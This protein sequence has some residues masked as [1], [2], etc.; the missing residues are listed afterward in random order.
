M[1]T[2]TPP[3]AALQWR[4]PRAISSFAVKALCE[5]VNGLHPLVAEILLNRGYS[6][7]DQLH[8]FFTPGLERVA[9]AADMLHL[10]RAALRVIHAMEEGQPILVYGDYDVDGTCS[11][12]MM[13]HFL[14]GLGAKCG[15]YNPD[16]YNEGYGVS[17]AGIDYAAANGYK[18]LLTLD[19]GIAAVERITE[20]QA[21]G[22]DVVVCDH[23]L[24]GDVMPPAYAILNPKQEG[25]PLN[26]EELCGCGVAFMLIRK[27][28]GLMDLPDAQWLHYLPYVAVATCCDIVDLKGINRSL[29]KAGLESMNANAPVGFAALLQVAGYQ[30]KLDVSDV[31]FKIGPRINAAGRLGHAR[32]AVQL[33]VQEQLSTALPLATG[34]EMRNRERRQLDKDTTAVAIDLMR[35]QDADLSMHS[36]LVKHPDWHKGVIGI[37]ASRLTEVCYRPTIVFAEGKGGQLTGSARSVEGFNLYE[38]IKDCAH[39]LEQFGGHRS[40]A[41]LS[42]KMERYEDFR[43]AFENS[44]AQRL[45]DHSRKPYLNV[46]IACQFSDWYNGQFN[47]F[48]NQLNRMRP[49]GPANLEP[50]FMTQ[51]AKAVD[52][53]T[54]GAEHLKFKAL[55]EGLDQGFDVIA[56]GMGHLCEQL[57]AGS[58]FDMVYTI[59]SNDWNGKRSF[60]L[61]AKDIR[62]R[63]S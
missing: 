5:Q 57:K 17:A 54:V 60:Q 52:V 49:F 51:G 6:S 40:A 50:Q 16:R 21:H 32:E 45:I 15:Y 47:G 11:T 61:E 23:H 1:T 20:A 27:I 38:A 28:S 30:G 37:V 7:E 3:R 44:V 35:A 22:I 36:T 10:E 41:G 14:Q 48:F 39:L 34:L 29:V 62:L 26:G 53:R 4:Q 46:D 24:P 13:Y 19:C 55:Q 56:F 18:L 8:T 33:L 43:N 63:D 25:C 31:V 9:S 58:A 2:E 12:A 42:L 59:G